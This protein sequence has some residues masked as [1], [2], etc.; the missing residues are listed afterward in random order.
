MGMG[1]ATAME[2]SCAATHEIAF[3]WLALCTQS[4]TSMH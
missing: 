2:A 1:T 4:G 3:V